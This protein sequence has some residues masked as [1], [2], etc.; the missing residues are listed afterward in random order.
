MSRQTSLNMWPELP[1]EQFKSTSYLLHMLTQVIGKL[2]LATPFEPHWANVP[3]WI[4][5]IGLSSGPIPYNQGTFSVDIDLINHLV[6]CTT[7]SG[8]MSKFGINSTSVA[9]L[10]STLLNALK[11]I[12]VNVK[13]NQMPQ[14]VANPIPFNEDTENRIY[15]TKLANAWWRIV[16]NSHRIMQRYHAKFTGITPPIG[17]MWGTFDLRDARYLNSPAP[18]TGANA[19]YLR[20]NA[21]DVAQVEAGWWS[22]DERYEKAAYFSFI[23]PQ[24]NGV[25]NAKIQPVNA[26]WDQKLGEFILDYDDV[27]KS[28][29][30]E[31]DLLAFFDSTYQVESKL[32]DWD[33]K[34]IGTGEP[35]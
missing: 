3:L 25:E 13:I 17:L 28:K 24:P 1:Y 26:R 7:M 22:G 5:S 10:T 6:I 8:N 9:K 16:A 19:G 12:G 33:P 15:D 11:G 32:A 20:R 4:T 34:L 14:E 31:A 29:N 2:K 27:R 35:V 21:M 30:P 18:T 23:Y